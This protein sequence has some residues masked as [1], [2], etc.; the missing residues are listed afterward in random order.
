MNSEVLELK[1]RQEGPA[2]TQSAPGRYDIYSSIHKALRSYMGETL[3]AVG[4]VDIH[5]DTEVSET[6][7]QV[8][9]LLE[10]LRLH[11]EAENR[12]LHMVMHDRSPGSADKTAVDH[13][14]HERSLARLETLSDEVQQ[15]RGDQ[16]RTAAKRLYRELAV[17][18]AENLEH[19]DYE[20]VENNAVLWLTHTDAELRQI[21][22][23]IVAGLSPEKKASVMRWMI[24]ALSPEE[25][26]WLLA[27]ARQTAPAPV[28][29][30]ILAIAKRALS[31]RDW[32]KLAAA[33]DIVPKAA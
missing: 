13:A 11:L 23:T 7:N 30:G 4:R 28:F 33:L 2:Q 16:R 25:R 3:A 32:T 8:R 20:E 9:G 24:P 14:G 19:M 5:D 22:Q 15:G 10:V 12:F 18:V 21:E 1:R 27:N 6:T 26:A 31:E 17:F 29:E